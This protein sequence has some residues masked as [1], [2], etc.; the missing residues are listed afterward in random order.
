MAEF[1][2]RS[3]T[4]SELEK[5]FPQNRLQSLE[6]RD[7]LANTEKLKEVF[8]AFKTSYEYY[9][10]MHTPPEERTIRVGF[11]PWEKLI[12]PIHEA[13]GDNSTSLPRKKKRYNP[14]ASV[15]GTALHEVAPILEVSENQ[16]LQEN[17]AKIFP[18]QKQ[19]FVD[20]Y[21]QA[22]TSPFNKNFQSVWYLLQNQD[23]YVINQRVKELE[24]F[25][26][27][28]PKE[29]LETNLLP[30][31]VHELEVRRDPKTAELAAKL[32]AHQKEEMKARG[33]ESEAFYEV[34]EISNLRN[35]SRDNLVRMQIPIRYDQIIKVTTKKGKKFYIYRDLK[36][37]DIEMSYAQQ[38]QALLMNYMARD[39]S[40]WASR[41]GLEV[42]GNWYIGSFGKRCKKSNFSLSYD[43]FNQET[44]TLNEILIKMEN[45]E[46]IDEF[47]DVLGIYSTI[48]V[49]FKSQIKALW[50]GQIDH[51]TPHFNEPVQEEELPLIYNSSNCNTLLNLSNIAPTRE[52]KHPEEPSYPLYR[53]GVS[54]SEENCPVCALPMTQ[55]CDRVTDLGG[56]KISFWVQTYC[57][58][59]HHDA[60]RLHHVPKEILKY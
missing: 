8:R 15:I 42:N 34:G 55:I 30:D 43:H 36:T 45:D 24:W 1:E 47:E 20:R 14:D 60:R 50:L 39:F 26:Q 19:E 3:T 9:K 35:A 49:A 16:Q 54:Q 38:F 10:L 23:L 58:G 33:K 44:N 4:T 7:V 17:V 41:K 32:S 22:I 57:P 37:G 27:E 2:K 59:H 53:L 11:T 21:A 28:Y 6:A 48:M 52:K 46:E 56:T 5:W 51:L 12:T 29:L 31:E 13:F 18:T 25:G 40:G